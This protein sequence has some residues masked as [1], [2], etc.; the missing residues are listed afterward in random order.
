MNFDIKTIARIGGLLYLINILL[1]FFAIGYV[2]GV[3]VTSNAVTTAQN[4]QTHEPLYRL[5]LACHVI[6]L[7]ANI[8]LALIFYRL[9]KNTNWSA[10][11]FVI[12]FTLVGTA[13]ECANLLN[14]F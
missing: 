8:P 14:Q 12:F 7:V 4:I 13:I 2:P 9:F 5:G 3:I 11:L 10:T 1:G 6:I